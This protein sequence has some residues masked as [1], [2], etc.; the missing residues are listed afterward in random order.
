MLLYDEKYNLIP[1]KKQPLE[2]NI[3]PLII[4]ISNKEFSWLPILQKA[5]KTDDAS[6]KQKI[7]L[8]AENDPTNGIIGLFN[9]IRREP[10]GERTRYVFS[11]LCFILAVLTRS[12]LGL[13]KY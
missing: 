6:A 10:G 4:K 13:V 9:C 11:V 3:V 12:C 8:V 7:I 1:I 2:Q 5:L